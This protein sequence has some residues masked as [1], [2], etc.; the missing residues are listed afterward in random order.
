MQSAAEQAEAEAQ[1]AWEREMELAVQGRG[2][3][4]SRSI[5]ADDED[6][7]QGS[8]RRR[9]G[10]ALPDD[11]QAPEF[12]EDADRRS[13]ARCF[14][15]REVGDS[16]DDAARAR[17]R[18]CSFSAL[19]PPRNLARADTE[20]EED[21]E[22]MAKRA[23]SLSKIYLAGSVPVDVSKLQ[24]DSKIVGVK[25]VEVVQPTG[26][27]SAAALDALSEGLQ[28]SVD[29]S[30]MPPSGYGDEQLTEE[31]LEE[32]KMEEEEDHKLKAEKLSARRSL[33]VRASLFRNKMLKSTSRLLGNSEEGAK[34]EAARNVGQ[35]TTGAEKLTNEVTADAVPV[36]PK[37]RHKL[38]LLLLGDSGVGK[39]SLMRVF[40]G[41]EFSESMLATAG[42]DFKLRHIN[43][44]DEAITLQIWDTAGQERFH[45]ITATY[46]KGANGIVLVYDVS[47]RR[48]F[49]N[50]GYWMN[51]IRQYSSLSQM[52]AM[53]LV[54]NKIDL[55]NRV[56]TLEEGQAAASQYG[57]RF[58]E[59]SAKTS[60]NTNGALE[61]IARD[62]YMISVNPTLTQRMVMDREKTLAGRRN[63]ENC[64]IQ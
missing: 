9:R 40:S 26:A 37:K 4:R 23:A 52:P 18:S 45:R 10:T 3:T 48:S 55:P 12:A 61:T 5:L 15:S 22:S 57:C 11:L 56:V 34:L 14:S 63:K 25:K 7:T 51:N 39:T 6:E 29:N 28:L 50:V 17:R 19:E 13:R 46:Y 59:T 21:A 36:A 16:E 47:D 1:L 30:P 8:D 58:I 62:A 41:D 35:R 20:A 53:L 42:V 60:E 2:R 27:L 38:K 24:D 31:Q 44:A 64:V 32:K 54:G 33:S 49:D 43:V